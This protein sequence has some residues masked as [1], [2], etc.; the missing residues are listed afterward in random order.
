MTPTRISF[1]LGFLLQWLPAN[2][3]TP[4]LDLTGNFT[5]LQREL[6]FQASSKQECGLLKQLVEFLKQL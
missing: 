2:E 1:F 4:P 6:L 5:L 3:L